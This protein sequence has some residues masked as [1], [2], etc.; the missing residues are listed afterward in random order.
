MAGPLEGIQVM[1]VATAVQ[2]PAAGLFLCDMGATVIRIEPPEGEA[3]RFFRGVGN[4][5]PAD[6]PGTQF[7]ATNRGKRFVV[8]DAQTDRG[9]EV[10]HKLA[11]RSDVFISNYRQ[12]ALDKLGLDYGTLG[13]LNPRLVYGHVNGFGPFGPD[14]GKPMVDGVGQA[15]GGLVNVN[16]FPDRPPILPG[17]VIADTGGAMHLALA[18]MTALV[19]RERTGKGQ[20]V[21]TSSLGAQLWLQAWE[22]THQSMTGRELERQGTYSPTNPSAYGTYETAD[23]KTLMHGGILSESSWRAFCEFAG[24]PDLANDGR[25]DSRE[26]RI[27]IGVSADDARALRPFMVRAFKSRTLAEWKEFIGRKVEDF[28]VETVQ[29]YQQVLDDP[30]NE[31]NEYLIERDIPHVG[32]RKVV[33]PGVYMSATPPDPG[34]SYASL[35]E[36]TE[37]VLTELGYAADEVRAIRHDTNQSRTQRGLPPLPDA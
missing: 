35:G 6:A 1:E 20:R 11:A 29:D 12:R 3:N 28:L 17:A 19:H 10:L 24:M 8:L 9:R 22:I 34:T 18:V 26:K 33:G 4:D 7:V 37:E 13:R 23:G 5:L 36:H 21:E 30:Q 31:A 25:F 15:R 16:G 2:G 27:G 14:T 32:K